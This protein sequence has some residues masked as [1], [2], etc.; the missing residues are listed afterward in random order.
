[1]VKTGVS[2]PEL[3]SLMAIL[4]P[5]IPILII[6][7]RRTWQQDIMIFLGAISLLSFMQHLMAYV[8][9]LAPVNTTFINS[10]FGLGEFALLLYLFRLVINT[11]WIREIMHA[12]LIA[13]TSVAITT[14]VLRGTET[15]SFIL[16]MTAAFLLLFTA[17]IALLQLIREKQ[18]FIFQ[19]PLF[20]VAGGSICYF[21]MF[22]LT[23]FVGKGTQALQQE[24]MILLSVINDIRFIFFIIAAYIVRPKK[25][26][27]EKIMS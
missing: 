16:S 4:L 3:L 9:T 1:M 26:Q 11:G 17:V 10:I 25:E 19:S 27:T 14:Y 13:F 22:I 5:V 7:I 20:W 8:P 6:F 21:S 2:I 24:K 15:H 12:I 23:G 18:L